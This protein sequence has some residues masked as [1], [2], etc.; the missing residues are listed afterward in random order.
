MSRALIVDDDQDV[1]EFIRTVV[2]EAGFEIQEAHHGIDALICLKTYPADIMIMDIK[3]PEMDGLELI[4]KVEEEFGENGPQIIILTG[5][6]EVIPDELQKKATVVMRK[7]VREAELVAAINR[8][9]KT[10]HHQAKSNGLRGYCSQAIEFINFI[11]EILEFF[12]KLIPIVIIKTI[13]LKSSSICG[14]SSTV[15]KS[16]ASIQN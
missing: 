11:K 12:R 8:F 1:R 7:P 16:E 15:G 10:R 5:Y 14:S 3:M 13:I 4:P 2:E 9:K 6:P